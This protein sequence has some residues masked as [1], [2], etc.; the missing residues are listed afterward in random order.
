MHPLLERQLKEQGVAPA[1]LSGDA[2]LVLRAAEAAL[3]QA[4]AELHDKAE[5][6]ARH[7]EKLALVASRTDNAVIITDVAH[8]GA[9][10]TYVRASRRTSFHCFPPIEACSQSTTPDTSPRS[11]KRMLRGQ[12]SPCAAPVLR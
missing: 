2:A 6:H 9:S 4:E 12:K 8:A 1:T 5:A 3:K 11:S 10:S 7:A